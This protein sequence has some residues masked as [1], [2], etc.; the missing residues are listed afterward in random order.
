MKK[1]RKLEFYKMQASGNDFVLIQAAGRKLQATGLNYKKLSKKLC[2]RRFGVGADGLLV[3]EPSKKVLF[4]MRIFNPDG[5]QAE[6]C[7]NGARCAALWADS[8]LQTPDSRLKKL[9]FETKAGVIYA[10]VSNKRDWGEVK[11]K[12]IDPFGLKLDSPIKVFKRKIKV[13]RI[14]TGVPHSV[15]FVEGIDQIN[16]V[17]IVKDIRFHRVLKPD[18][19]KVEYVE[20]IIDGLFIIIIC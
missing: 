4:K 3:I 15:V 2:R 17:E 18:C 10:R 5:S 19:T 7:G 12:M 13:N 14:N 20:F 11:I 9:E 6:M 1:E 8:R 16:A